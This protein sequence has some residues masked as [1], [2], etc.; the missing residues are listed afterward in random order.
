M[1]DDFCLDAHCDVVL[2][3]MHVPQREDRTQLKALITLPQI[4]VIDENIRQELRR[5]RWLDL[6]VNHSIGGIETRGGFFVHEPKFDAVSFAVDWTLEVGDAKHAQPVTHP[7][8]LLAYWR[9]SDDQRALF[10]RFISDRFAIT[11]ADVAKPYVQLL[12]AGLEW[13]LFVLRKVNNGLFYAAV[14]LFDR[15]TGCLWE[16]V[17]QFIAW[18]AAVRGPKESIA[19]WEAVCDESVWDAPVNIIN[20]GLFACG[21]IGHRISGEM[22][23]SLAWVLGRSFSRT[24]CNP[25]LQKRVIDRLNA[26]YP[27][28][29]EI[30][31][32][33]QKRIACFY[34]PI[35]PELNDPMIVRCVV[36]FT[37]EIPEMDGLAEVV[38][39]IERIAAD[40][41][42][43]PRLDSVKMA[44][45]AVETAQVQ[46]DLA[47]L[48]PM[49]VIQPAAPFKA[50]EPL[51]CQDQ[52]ALAELIHRAAWTRDDF[53]ALARKHHTMPF[54]LYEKLNSWCVV[55]FGEPLL[56]GD[57]PVE[58]DQTVNNKLK[59]YA[60]H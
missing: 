38:A 12:L 26:V 14:N 54:A 22:I 24:C 32:S 11:R 46:A 33:N 40:V 44:R 31:L 47:A 53:F 37:V 19:V 27:A 39:R 6:G 18:W 10:L 8:H 1:N 29:L 15:I 34:R 45:T 30:R 21:Q 28:G 7:T 49:N 17:L 36:P 13:H 20:F 59:A 25:A 43:G 51:S 50:D 57:G 35:C 2:T 23:F 5:L 60:N 55:T 4:T 56:I 3:S 9:L 52:A 42:S 48:L 41:V 16:P 58:I